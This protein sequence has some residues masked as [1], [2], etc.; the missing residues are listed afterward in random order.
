MKLTVKF[1]DGSVE[2]YGLLAHIIKELIRYRR[3]FD[4]PGIK[5]KL[6]IPFKDGNTDSN[7]NIDL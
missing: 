3:V 6:E 7:L 5:G 4:T 1:D 2:I